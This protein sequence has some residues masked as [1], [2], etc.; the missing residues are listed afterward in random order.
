MDNKNDNHSI[1]NKFP[2]SDIDGS[3]QKPTPYYSKQRHP[4]KYHDSIN[5]LG[6]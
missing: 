2:M 1:I 4:G 5:P 6:H 3:P